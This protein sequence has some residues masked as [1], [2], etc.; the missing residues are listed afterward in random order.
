MP[1]L[2]TYKPPTPRLLRDFV[3]PARAQHTLIIS[4]EVIDVG[5]RDPALIPE[6]QLALQHGG[7]PVPF[8]GF[9]DKPRRLIVVW[10]VGNDSLD[11][12][13]RSVD[14]FRRNTNGPD[15]PTARA[16]IPGGVGWVQTTIPCAACRKSPG[17]QHMCLRFDVHFQRVEIW[18]P[19]CCKECV[20]P[21]DPA[22]QDIVLRFRDSNS[23]RRQ[24]GRPVLRLPT[25]IRLAGQGVMEIQYEA[26]IG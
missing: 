25:K 9:E 10:E 6:C 5:A 16:G 15:L 7:P 8:P 23:D 1:F 11:F 12:F 19:T 18:C 13:D 3:S 14:G 24:S 22:N 4:R 2:D 20:P 21:F 17:Q 26:G